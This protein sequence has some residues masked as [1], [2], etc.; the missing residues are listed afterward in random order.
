MAS[1]KRAQK[2]GR[3][4]KA[5][6]KPAKRKTAALQAHKDHVRKNGAARGK[7]GAVWGSLTGQGSQHTA[8][9]ARYAAL[10]V[11]TVLAT[12]ETMVRCSRAFAELPL[13]AARA[14]TPSEMWSVHARFV[15]DVVSE[16]LAATKR[17]WTLAA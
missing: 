5:L 14:R 15:Q 13:R 9:T 7:N 11:N 16:G 17:F 4:G 10:P 1:S 3:P 8:R 2:K 6:K 12:A